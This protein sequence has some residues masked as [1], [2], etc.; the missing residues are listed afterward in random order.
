MDSQPMLDDFGDRY[1]DGDLSALREMRARG[2]TVAE[3][4]TRLGRTEAGV[5]SKLRRLRVAGVEMPKGARAL[6]G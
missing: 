3:I 5:A 1:D 4:A 6:V 2:F